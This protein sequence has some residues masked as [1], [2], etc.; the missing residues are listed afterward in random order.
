VSLLEA[1]TFQL[2]G[3]GSTGSVLQPGSLSHQLAAS[4]LATDPWLLGLGLMALPAGLWVRRLRPPAVAL[5]ALVVM[6][7]RPGYLPQPYVIALLPFCAVMAMGALDVAW[8]RIG[9]TARAGSRSPPPRCSASA[10]QSAPAGSRRT[11]S[12]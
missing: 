10:W 8:E 6:A 11:A 5:L 2:F 7:V 4:W 12:R 1:A 9:R 3:R